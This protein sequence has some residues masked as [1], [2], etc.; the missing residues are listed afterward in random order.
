MEERKNNTNKVNEKSSKGT[1]Q[2]RPRTNTK[3]N[4]R[5]K[6]NINKNKEIEISTERNS[7]LI[8]DAKAAL[9]LSNVEIE[10]ENVEP[11]LSVEATKNIAKKTNVSSFGKSKLK[12]IPLGGMNEIGKNIT[13][14]EYENEIIV[15]DCGLAFPEDEMLGV[16][17]VIPDISYL[18]KNQEK[19]KAIVITHGHEDHIGAIPYFL[20]KINVPIY[21]T[22]LTL[23]LIKNKLI[24]HNLEKKTKLKCIKARDVVKFGKNFK[25]E[26]IK[27][28]HSI[29]DSVALA[30]TTPHGVVIHTGDFKVDYTPIDGE[31]MD[32]QRL[33]ELGKEGVMLLMSDST[34]VQRPGHTMSESSVGKEFDKI[35]T[36]C[37]KRI[38]V[39]TFAS[40]I[41]RMQ[42]IIN[43]AVKFKRKV[44]VVGRSM[45]NVLGVAQELGYLTAPEGA[46]I[47][48]D[49]IGLYNPEQIVIITTGSQGE[50]MAALSRMSAGEHR[51]VQ[52]T[53]DDLIIFSSSPI[54][55]NEKSVGRVI[56]ELEK[57][58]AEVI[59]NQLADVHVSGH[60][61]QE[62]LKLMLCLTKP[63]YFM[64]VH[65]E[66]RFLKHH[67][68]LAVSVGTP[69][70]NIFIMENGRT[71]E[72]GANS[73]N[74]T[75]Q[76]TSGMVLVD[77][78]GVGDVG[79]IVLRDRQLLSENGMII[80]VV[81]L[82][83]KTAKVISG[84]DIVTRGFVYVRESETL[85]EE[86]KEIAKKELEK[87][88]TEKVREWS[89]IKSNL[90]DSMMHYIYSKT[91]RQP[92]ILP[93]LM[94]V[95]LER[96]L[97]LKRTD[98][99]VKNNDTTNSNTT[100]EN[101]VS[102]KTKAKVFKGPRN[103]KVM[104]NINI[105]TNGNTSSGNT[106]TSNN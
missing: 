14:F 56:D 33:G 12:I 103:V 80:I 73:A 48:I 86:I 97:S 94:D 23:G 47:D 34:N 31:P 3:T 64:P 105:K 35:F 30:I 89:N 99:L 1:V 25:V 100:N 85:M 61:C 53:A 11:I 4:V 74:I 13:V 91:K 75:T 95:D 65:G 32:F 59:Y 51:K 42:Q 16:D 96:T 5:E 8:K 71:L 29:A 87:C 49:K 19:I 67:G 40:N 17:L 58:G 21:G 9:A 78:L 70:E 10:I 26:F 50:P 28:T 93:I 45:I 77:G 88:E 27:M 55:G 36:N 72:I 68:E 69:K 22:K 7:K 92:M 20:K 18:E 43:S 41:H 2:R 63:K 52:V 54:P 46:I 38:I 57:L 90:R 83:R 15:V 82:D 79:N 37:A 62:E 24:E 76:V 44:A 106:T 84:P 81:T 6:E 66:Y 39:A 60:A 104:R 98:S 101:N 102:S